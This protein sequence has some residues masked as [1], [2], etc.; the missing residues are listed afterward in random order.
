MQCR[1]LGRQRDSYVMEDE[2][3]TSRE[4]I[5][6]N[7]IIEA[8]VNIKDFTRAYLS[9]GTNLVTVRSVAPAQA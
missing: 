2:G 8:M 7:R 4:E 3:A 1:I 5:K 9:A 6:M